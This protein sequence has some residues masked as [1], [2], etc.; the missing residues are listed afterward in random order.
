MLHIIVDLVIPLCLQAVEAFVAWF[1]GRGP[2]RTRSR[3]V[4]NDKG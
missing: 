3:R 2:S 1:S 4:E